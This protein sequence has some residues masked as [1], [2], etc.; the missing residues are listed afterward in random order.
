MFSI[1]SHKSVI[2]LCQHTHA[3]Y[4]TQKSL[5]IPAAQCSYSWIVHVFFIWIAVKMLCWLSIY[6]PFRCMLLSTQF[7]ML[8][9]HTNISLHVA[10]N[11][12]YI[13]RHWIFYSTQILFTCVNIMCFLVGFHIFTPTVTCYVSHCFGL[14]GFLLYY[15]NSIW[16]YDIFEWNTL[17]WA[18]NSSLVIFHDD[19]MTFG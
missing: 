12:I 6:S 19:W 1:H 18:L 10:F 17:F 9:W 15:D 16:N 4:T 3:Q 14:K 5:F 8:H 11:K 13:I 7:L 2:A